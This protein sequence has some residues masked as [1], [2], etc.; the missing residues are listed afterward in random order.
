[1]TII[2]IT[3]RDFSYFILNQVSLIHISDGKDPELSS[4]P[5][6]IFSWKE[7]LIRKI[8][9]QRAKIPSVILLALLIILSVIY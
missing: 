6:Q 3:R 1:M 5:D 4:Y 2:Y 9:C 7:I 8:T